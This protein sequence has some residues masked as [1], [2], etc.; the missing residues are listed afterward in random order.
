MKKGQVAFLTA[1]HVVNDLYQGAVPALLP[2]MML[3]RGYSYSAVA[4]IT[5]TRYF[6]S[7]GGSRLKA[8]LKDVA[9]PT[10][11]FTQ[12]FLEDIGDTNLW[13]TVTADPS[14][15]A[16]WFGAAETP[17]GFRRIGLAHGSVQG[18]LAEG[19]DSWVCRNIIL[20]I[21]GG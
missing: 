17:E 5:P 7:L 10:S 19:I 13:A 15:T 18:I 1:T 2:F 12:Q 9:S 11:A 6:T 3:E 20:V 21:F 16:E 4:G 14:R 8:N